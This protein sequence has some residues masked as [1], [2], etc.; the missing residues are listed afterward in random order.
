LQE[1]HS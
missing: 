1:I